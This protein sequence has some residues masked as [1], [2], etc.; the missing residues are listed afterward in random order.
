MMWASRNAKH[1]TCGSS[2]SPARVFKVACRSSDDG[3][4]AGG[5]Q[6]ATVASPV[7]ENNPA[8]EQASVSGCSDTLIMRTS[9]R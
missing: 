9:G 7:S 5:G 1:R 2:Y 6:T 4:I 8:V 3:S